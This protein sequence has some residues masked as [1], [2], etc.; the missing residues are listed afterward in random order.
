MNRE[1]EMH[2]KAAEMTAPATILAWLMFELE[3]RHGHG[4]SSDD[5]S[6]LS[7]CVKAAGLRL[8]EL[9]PGG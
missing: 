1:N 9:E 6:R 7:D 5:L 3:S 4:N 2:A 8:S